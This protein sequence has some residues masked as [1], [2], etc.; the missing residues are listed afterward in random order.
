MMDE[1]FF[2]LLKGKTKEV[3]KLKVLEIY[4][5]FCRFC[6]E[7]MKFFVDDPIMMLITL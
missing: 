4:R 7:K 5:Y 6:I 3:K 2:G 1:N